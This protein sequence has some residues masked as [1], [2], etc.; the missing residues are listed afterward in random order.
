M[1]ECIITSS[2][3]IA[4]LIALRFLF[5]GKISSR[6]QYALWGLVLLRLLMPFSLFGSSVSVMNAVDIPGIADSLSDIEVYSDIIR[7]SELSPDEAREAGNGTLHEIQ[8]YPVESGSEHLRTY[9]FTD[10]LDVVL[11][12]ILKIAWLVGGI[13]AGLWILGTNLVFYIGLRKS[14]RTYESADCRLPVYVSGSIASPCLFGLI[15]PAIY[16]T[17]K[18]AESEETLGYVLA[19]ELGHYRHGDHFWS[20]VRGLCLAAYWWNPLVW[21]AAALSRSDGELACD[22]AV[23][24]R[25]GE[26]SRLA[27]GRA[28]VDMIAEKRPPAGFLHAATTMSSGSHGIRTRLSMIVRRPKALIPAAIAVVLAA[29]I[30]AVCTFTGAKAADPLSAEEA[31]E[32]LAASV[33]HLDGQVGFRIPQ[34]YERPEEWNIHIAGRQ[35][36]EDGFSRSVHL[37]EDINEDNAWEPGRQYTL[38]LDDAYTELTLTAVL[39]DGRGGTLE[40]E[41][42]MLGSSAPAFPEVNRVFFSESAD[43]EQLGRDAAAFYYAQ[44]TGDDIPQYWRITKYE[45][46]ACELMAG[47]QAECAVWITSAVE[48]EGAG[49]LIGEGI[50]ADPGDAA[51][52]GICPEVGR[53]FRIRA[54]GEG[55]YEIVGV[56]TGGGDQGLA[57]AEGTGS[58]TLTLLENGEVLRTIAPLTGDGAELAEEAI[59]N[60][61]IKSAAW[62]GFGIGTLDECC[63]LSAT[64]S[65][66]ATTDYYA[67]EVDGNAVMQAGAE[68]Y[69]S[70]IDDGLYQELV[71]LAQ[72]SLATV[73]GVGGPESVSVGLDRTDLDTC[74][75]EAVINENAEDFSNGDFAAEA[76]TILKSVENGDT[77]TVYAVALYS[78]FGYA[79][80]GF[81]ETGGSHM[82]AAMT[83]EKN[84]A[85]E[86][87]LIEYWTPKDGTDYA[88]SIREKFPS[89][90]CED[91]LNTQKYILSHRQA[92]Y[93]QAVEYGKVSTE[94]VLAG[95]VEEIGSSPAEA[96]NPGAYIQ[97]H[98]VE[99]G[100]LLYYGD[101]TL[102]YAYAAFLKGGQTGLEGHI[103]L[104]AMRE[105]LGKEDIQLL[106]DTGQDWFDE[107]KAQAVRL[108]DDNSMEFMEQNYPKTYMLLQM[109]DE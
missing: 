1:I 36:F 40:T 18:A 45:I 89:D 13:A 11:G 28:L 60:Y 66:G 47:D 107:W 2:V 101:Y 74:V 95:L 61:V 65:D 8:G 56:G 50:P 91:A 22:E 86:Y 14:R 98:P 49:F 12:R 63:R 15:R 31:L 85:G 16:L 35:E 97:A 54:L 41:V 69:Y 25:F 93:A 96:S 100:E 78:V 71:R 57:P 104:A 92:C 43:P 59:M 58:Y 90:I 83:F 109:P 55:R 99:Y 20:V 30:C 75:A 87:E 37:L 46:L 64:Y 102:R 73:G 105:L 80:A 103:I 52:G 29:A 68:G 26:S 108:L 6:L 67:Y 3:L 70:R 7:F 106:A 53:Q 10:S 82:P 39:P 38:E 34:G 84:A 62:P 19:H 4:A 48:T 88:P 77:T 76:H 5:K 79:G 51:K 72:G 32:Q 44:F 17:P 94:A 81:S 21:I 27:Y 33:T 42:D 9:I 24:R 23:I